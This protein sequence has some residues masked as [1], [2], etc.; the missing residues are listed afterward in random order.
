[1]MIDVYEETRK[2]E[3]KR[4]QELDVFLVFIKSLYNSI[5]LPLKLS[6]ISFRLITTLLILRNGFIA[7]ASLYFL[8]VC[9]CVSDFAL[10]FYGKEV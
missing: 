9:T 1:M 5:Q 10:V 2:M 8:G 4:G 3:K 6:C 7:S